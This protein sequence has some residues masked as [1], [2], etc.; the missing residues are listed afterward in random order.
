MWRKRLT[1]EKRKNNPKP[2]VNFSGPLHILAIQMPI[3]PL[4][5]TFYY[6]IIIRSNVQGVREFSGRACFSSSE[7]PENDRFVFVK[8]QWSRNSLVTNQ[9]EPT[10][11][12]NR[13]YDAQTVESHTK[14]AFQPTSVRFSLSYWSIDRAFDALRRM[15]PPFS[16]PRDQGRILWGAEAAGA[17]LSPY[18]VFFIFS[19]LSFVTIL[20]RII[21]GGK[22]IV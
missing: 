4:N 10:L 9:R 20:S 3:A 5:F 15:R 18:V 16:S 17:H 13:V 6:T 19:F 11:R 12:P 2:N 21:Y 7:K 1:K 8:I 14:S 22:E